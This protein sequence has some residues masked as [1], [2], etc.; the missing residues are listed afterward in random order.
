MNNT[1]EK[2]KKIIRA[3]TFYDWANS[4]YPL[5][6]TTAIFPIFYEAVT[7]TLLPDGSSNDKVAFF[8]RTYINTALISYASAAMFLLVSFLIPFLSGIADY[9]G[10]KKTFMRFFCYLGSFSCMALFF[11]TPEKLEWGIFT[12]MLAGIGFWGSLVFYNAYLPEIAPPEAHDRISAQGYALG[13]I[14]SAILLLACLGFI[15][16]DTLPAKWSFVFTGLWWFG[17]SHYTLYMLPSTPS[18][19]IRRTNIFLKGFKELQQVWQE[20]KQDTRLKRY[21]YAFFVYSMAVQTIM[22]M[23]VYFGTKEVQWPQED[24]A[25]SGLIISVLLIQLIAIPGAYG[26]SALSG[27]IG[28]INA[29]ITVVMLWI[30]ICV[31]ALWVYLPWQFYL[32]AAGVGLV[33][34]GIQSLSRSTYAKFLPPTKDTSS[35]FSFYDVAEKVG[36]V[37]GVFSYGLIEEFTG[38]MRNSIFVLAAFFALGAFL[39]FRVPAKAEKK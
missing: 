25:R 21:L 11:F 33:M 2:Q 13:Y 17:F 16:T 23:A 20:I 31:L 24:D 26:L 30:I 7:T 29:L 1:P 14:G 22:L 15:L 19:E 28:N 35:Y 6:I 12:Y 39:L 9:M 38:S 18:A 32:I 5:V 3:W 37:I 27:R 34:G 36:I 10:N 4:S 8:G